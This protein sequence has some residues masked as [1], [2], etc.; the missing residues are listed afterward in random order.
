HITW[1]VGGW[2][3]R[4]VEHHPA[5]DAFLDTGSAD[6]PVKSF[7]GFWQFVQQMRA[8][9]FDMVV[10]LVRSPLM[11][12]AVLLSGIP[13]RVGIDSNGRGFGYTLRHKIDPQDAQHEAQIYLDVDGQLG[14]P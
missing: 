9:N 10:S 6:M 2:S 1:A 4:A 3:R 7:K 8:G 14:I 11:S 13:Q 12:L 5:I